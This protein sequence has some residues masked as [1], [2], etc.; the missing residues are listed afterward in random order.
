MMIPITTKDLNKILYENSVT[1]RFFV[2][3]H[4]SCI[5]PKT[6]KTFYSFITNTQNHDEFGGHWNAW[7]VDGKRLTFFDSFGRDPKDVT[8]PEHYKD[9]IR[10]FRIVDWVRTRVQGWDSKACGYFCV[11]FIYM[12]S[13]GLNIKI[14][15]REYTSD[16][17]M[18]DQIVFDFVSSIIS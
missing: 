10:R 3:T 9:F 5:L 14:F 4:P 12:L 7:I 1:K 15:L 13:L 17:E 2:G 6:T 16:F 11:H 8:L 18:N